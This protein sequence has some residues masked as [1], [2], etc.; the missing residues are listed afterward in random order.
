MI[1][2]ARRISAWHASIAITTFNMI[3]PLTVGI[4]TS[5]ES[6]PEQGSMSASKYLK[7]T[8]FRWF[9][10]AFII[11]IVTPFADTLRDGSDDY[12][13]ESVFVLFFFDMFSRPI[14]QVADLWGTVHR[15][16]FA[17]RAKDQ[18]L[19]NLC[20]AAGEL[21]IGDLYTEITRYELICFE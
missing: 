4:L 15:H 7:V 8:A 1:A 17:P 11:Q 21:D 14:L 6:H 18:R 12:L 3:T 19:M 5:Y 20:F 9:N 16:F 10:T 2:L 13:L